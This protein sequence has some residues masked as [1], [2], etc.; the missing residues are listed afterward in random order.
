MT[1]SFLFEIEGL[2]GL[3]FT[4]DLKNNL[5][6]TAKRVVNS[7]LER[8]KTKSAKELSEQVNFPK[9]YFK[10]TNSRLQISSRPSLERLQGSVT[11][12]S[13]PTSLATFSSKNTKSGPIRV[14]VKPGRQATLPTAFFLKLR[15]GN[16][17][18]DQRFNLG[19]AIRTANGQPPKTAYKPLKIGKNLYLLY[20]PSVNQVFG[21]D[22][23]V[24]VKVTP[25][26]LQFMQ[27]EFLRLID[28]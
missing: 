17:G 12:R 25:D 7:A 5:Q 20:G 13:R 24:A 18:I 26:L 27:D 4:E 16:S 1:K 9:G 14:S 22:K 10:G 11:G 21:G 8:A 3:D 28:L 2:Q 19:V 23:G 6:E 15:A